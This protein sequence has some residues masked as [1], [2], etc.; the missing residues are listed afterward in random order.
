[1]ASDRADGSSSEAEAALMTALLD[2]AADAVVVSDAEGCILRANAA[3]EALFGHAPGALEG[4]GVEVLMPRAYAERHAGFMRHHLE[5]GERR[6][7]GIGREVEGRRADGSVFPLHLSVGRA[8]LPQG[9]GFVAILHDLTRRRAAEA[10]LARTE[11]M[12][13]LGRMTGGVAHDFNNLL[14]VVIGNLELLETRVGE[15]DRPLLGDAL[16]AAQLGA[17]LTTRLLA[18]ARR[19]VLAPER[20]APAVVVEDTAALLRRTLGPKVDLG[21]RGAACG[22]QIEVDRSQL[23]SALVNLALNARDAM[24]EGGRLV[25][26]TDEVEID[27]AY[28]AQELDVAPGRYARVTVADDGSGMDLETQARAFEPFFTTKGAGQGTGLGL[29]MVYGFVR[30]SG[31]HATLYSEVGHGTTVALY[32]PLAG[33]EAVAAPGEADPGALPRGRG[34]RV[35]VVEDDPAVRRLSVARLEAL[36]YAVDAAADADEAV[37]RLARGPAP[38]AVFTDLVMPGAMS[39]TDLARH[40]ARHHP[41]TAVLM[42]SGSAGTLTREGDREASLPMLRKPFRQAELAVRLREALDSR[43]AGDEPEAQPSSTSAVKE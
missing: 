2:A 3:A 40:V 22:P 26:A 16:A 25:F 5:T 27:D 20:L 37:R 36:G 34:E 24:P 28:V 39:G 18:F 35:L 11:R 8:D 9:P 7:I 33:A 30:Q 13:A 6:I 21:V 15:Q 43:V 23:Q 14:A 41:G 29:A 31:G 32:F 4:Q 42:T 10:A 19:G 1:M 38:E 17:D 12:D